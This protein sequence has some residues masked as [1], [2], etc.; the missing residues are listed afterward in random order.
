M[1]PA[2]F[3]APLLALALGQ[4]LYLPLDDR[5]PNLAPCAWGPVLCPPREAYR[6]PE[7]ADA[8]R[9]RAW[10]LA[11]PGQRLVASLDV[12]AY[13][14]LLQSRHLPL[15]PEDALARLL[16]LLSWKVRHGGEVYLF[17]VI[18]RWDA[19]FRERNLQVLKA[20]APWAGL[21]GVY[22]EAVW[23]DAVRGSPAPRE[24]A[25]LPYP[26]RPGADEAGQ[27]LL[28]RASR[29]GLKVAV[30][31]ETPALARQVTPYEG[32][33]LEET[34]ARLLGSA[35]ARPT[36]LEEGPDLVLYVYGGKSPR[37]AALDLL[38]LMARHPVALADLSRVNRGDPGLMAY[39]QGLG[40]YGRLFAYA[41]WGTPANNLGSALAQGGLFLGDREGRLLRL[42]EAYF[43]YW[44]GEVGRPWV[45]ARFPE[46]LPEGAGEV[47]ALWP[48]LVLEGRRVVLRRVAF[49][50]KRAFEA[51]PSLGWVPADRGPF[52]VR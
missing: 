7:G 52:L 8:G 26:S 23:D 2:L 18:P 24:A 32:L 22:L 1:R 9:L 29:P 36:A 4:T 14:G 44:W 17:G 21:G 33:P 15:A 47:A 41:A 45:R 28:L 3:L 48:H 34:V 31:Y 46:P 40:L 49:P 10:L 12:L 38:R 42:A 11:T 37:Q 35:A 20:L 6:G 43:G 27:V 5:P 39:L 50:W 16:P 25:L 19:T 30:V 51:E 13:G